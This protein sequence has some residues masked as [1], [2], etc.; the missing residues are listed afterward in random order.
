MTETYPTLRGVINEKSRNIE[1]ITVQWPFLKEPEFI[2]QH[3][4]ILLGKNISNGW[5]DSLS[6]KV[7]P[8]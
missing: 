1:E 7:K 4:F 6:K 3:S 2:L 8:I 5:S